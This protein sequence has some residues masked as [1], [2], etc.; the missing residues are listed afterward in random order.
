MARYTQTPI[1]FGENPNT[2]REDR[3]PRYANVKYPLIPKSINDIYVLV[4]EGDRF[5]ILAQQ[6]YKDSSLWWIISTANSNTKQNSLI[7]SPSSQI[8]IPAASRL[9]QILSNYE[10]LNF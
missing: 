4:S 7:P 5:D 9:N 3:Y 1:T 6:Y 2:N 10:N 8:R